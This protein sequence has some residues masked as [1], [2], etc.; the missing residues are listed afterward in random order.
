MNIIPQQ[1]NPD[2]TDL[3]SRVKVP[4]GWGLKQQL[5]LM[6]NKTP[7]P[8]KL[9]TSFEPDLFG[10]GGGKGRWVDPVNARGIPPELLAAAMR[11][12]YYQ[13]ADQGKVPNGSTVIPF[14]PRGM[15]QVPTAP[16]VPAVLVRRAVPDGYQLWITGYAFDLF[17]STTNELNYIWRLFVNGQDILNHG[18]P[19]P[20]RGRPVLSNEPVQLGYD[21]AGWQLARAGDVVEVVVQAFAAVGA[22]DTITATVFGNLEAV[23]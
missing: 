20:A 19:T 3:E 2:R 22:S 15:A 9:A 17:P 11:T 13:V 14:A 16:A 18:N 10:A 5:D 21:K 1:N 4:A 7:F 6:G 23:R 8:D 12:Y